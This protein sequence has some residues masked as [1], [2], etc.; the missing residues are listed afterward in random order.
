MPTNTT[1]APETTMA[2]DALVQMLL[3][4]AGGT[5]ADERDVVLA[6]AAARWASTHAGWRLHLCN[7]FFVEVETLS[8]WILAVRAEQLLEIRVR[9]GPGLGWHTHAQHHIAHLGHGLDVLAAEELLP[10]RFSTL[11]RLALE[12]FAE[13]LDRGATAMCRRPAPGDEDPD[14]FAWE[15]KIRAAVMNRAADQARA[16][17]RSELAVT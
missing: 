10:A 16:F 12:D 9:L 5:V 4:V 7:S 8:W 13:S 3:D 11:G 15:M 1:S 17:P 2:E 14:I 6:R